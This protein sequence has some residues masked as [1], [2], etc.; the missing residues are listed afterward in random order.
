MLM[1]YIKYKLKSSNNVKEL[2][3]VVIRCMKLE[4]YLN[5]LF[6]INYSFSNNLGQTALT[7]FQKGYLDQYRDY[8]IYSQSFIIISLLC[9]WIFICLMKKTL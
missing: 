9:H 8:H 5:D 4:E 1:I 2:C 6:K 3:A 7:I